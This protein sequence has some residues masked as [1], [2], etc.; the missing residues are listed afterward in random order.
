[1][2][3]KGLGVSE[4]I[5]MYNPLH[6]VDL[7][8]FADVADTVIGSSKSENIKNFIRNRCNF[9]PVSRHF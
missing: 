4:V 6:E 5:K 2:R 3:R 8:K 1:M 9:S 7:S